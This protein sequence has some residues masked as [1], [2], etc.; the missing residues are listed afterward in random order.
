[1]L[2]TGV[3]PEGFDDRLARHAWQRFTHATGAAGDV[4]ARL[5]ALGS[6]DEAARLDAYHELLGTI[7]HEG[8]V[9]DA[10]SR[11][12]PFL[13]E[14]LGERTTPDRNRIAL[15]LGLLGDGVSEDLEHARRARV[16]VRAGLK[17]YLRVVE[18]PTSGALRAGLIY[19]LAH[20][21]LD[22]ERVIARIPEETIVQA[23]LNRPHEHPRDGS[24]CEICAPA[25]A[26]LLDDLGPL[27]DGGA[28]NF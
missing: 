21:P 9:F 13:V 6:D 18:E 2:E 11:A 7:W 10:T 8:T 3:L 1:M 26:E 28:G 14:L 16:E 23:I 5:R 19:L 22:A 15:L 24:A 27:A 25:L 12:V 17:V 20:F 4:P